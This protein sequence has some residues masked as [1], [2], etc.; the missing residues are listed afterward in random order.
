MQKRVMILGRKL[1][2]LRTERYWTQEE[3]AARL[4]MSPGNVRRLEQA[5]VSGIQVKNFRRLAELLETTPG[6]LRDQIGA[7]PEAV[8]AGADARHPGQV[9]AAE[10][11]G[12][13]PATR[14]NGQRHTE[15]YDYGSQVEPD[16]DQPSALELESVEPVVEIER[17]HGV[18]AARPEERTDV[19]GGTVPVPVGSKPGARRFSVTV[20][21]DC[22]EPKYRHGDVVVFSV[23][24]AERGGIVD[25]KNYFIQFDDGENTFKR[26]YVD[27]AH[28]DRVILR[29]WNKS[30]PPRTVERRKIKL[31]AR[32]VY[33]LLPDD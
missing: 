28:R 31:L 11:E 22:M 33:R 6:Q 12:S 20:D 9:E 19:A 32:A 7:P 23:D 24:A 18:S 13:R 2:A 27:P 15:T 1:A 8:N 14:G 16:N 21:G 29:C 10:R 30:Y 4:Q 25:G 5:D 17:F 26:V 3:F